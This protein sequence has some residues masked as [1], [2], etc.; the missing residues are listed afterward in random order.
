MNWISIEKDVIKKIKR[1]CTYELQRKGKQSTTLE[2]VYLLDI[3]KSILNFCT[4]STLWLN[5]EFFIIIA[6]H[7]SLAALQWTI[8]EEK[9]TVG[10]HPVVFLWPGLWAV[11]SFKFRV[12]PTLSYF[13][14][15]SRSVF[16]IYESRNK[17]SHFFITEL[18]K[19]NND[20]FNFI[21]L[22]LS[23]MK[24]ELSNAHTKVDHYKSRYDIFW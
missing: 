16:C 7:R 9:L 17:E 11:R 19:R 13:Y 23:K 20:A 10:I 3:I 22:S 18:W 8:V 15:F 14:W 2:P 21:V 4:N 6:V 12:L 24:E 1:N 5:F